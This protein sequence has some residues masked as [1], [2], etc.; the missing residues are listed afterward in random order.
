VHR[1]ID[2]LLSDRPDDRPPPTDIPR[3]D[4]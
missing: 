2:R 3:T 4:L 1:F